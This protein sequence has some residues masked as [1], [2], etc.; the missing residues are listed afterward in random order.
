M[1]SLVAGVLIF[2]SLIPISWCSLELLNSQCME[3]RGRIIII[4]VF[5]NH[6][7]LFFSIVSRTYILLS[8]SMLQNQAQTFRDSSTLTLCFKHQCIMFHSTRRRNVAIN[9]GYGYSD[10]LK[11]TCKGSI[12]SH[13][14]MKTLHVHMVVLKRSKALRMS[15]MGLCEALKSDTKLIQGRLIECQVNSTC[16]ETCSL[17]RYMGASQVVKWTKKCSS[18]LKP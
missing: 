8:P 1:C 2:P 3:T 7:K 5:F 14:P 11:L 9:L 17:D 10:M 15:V 12:N 4:I 16:H 18:T 6:T 13:F